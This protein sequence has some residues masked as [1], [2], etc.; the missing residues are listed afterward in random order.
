M[1]RPAQLTAD[2]RG[3]MAALESDVR[4]QAKD[5][6]IDGRLRPEW[7]SA[8]A[9]SRSSADYESWR[10]EQ[11]TQIAAAWLLATLFLRFC[12]DNDLI[13]TP[14]LAGPQGR[15]A[16]A[17]DLQRD[18]VRRTPDA[19]DRQWIL[20]GL[21]EINASLT[22]P[23]PI[24]LRRSPMGLMEIS[25]RATDDL[26]AFWRTRKNGE[27][28]HDFTDA[29]WDTSFLGDVYQN[30]SDRMRS[31]D[32]MLQTPA[33]AEEFILDRALE[34]AITRFGLPGLRIID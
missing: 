9:A 22:M 18:F 10:E 17:E 5:P 32:A 12:E 23:G 3:Q 19:S 16:K 28:V 21:K 15:L 31:A 24:D 14:Y 34:P 2:L 20:R 1:V 8:R 27:I 11:V 26:I 29:A 6:S 30:L 33:I 7:Q 25:D 4:E 13:S